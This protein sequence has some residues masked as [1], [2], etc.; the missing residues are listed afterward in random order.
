VLAAP[1]DALIFE[2][3]DHRLHTVSFL[4]D[5]LTDVGIAFLERIGR[6]SSPPLATR[7]STYTVLLEEAPPGRYPFVSEGHGGQASGVI[8]VEDSAAVSPEV[9][10]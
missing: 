1:G 2:T 8:V 6:L 5:S 4:P 3:V 9:G 7:G 10:S